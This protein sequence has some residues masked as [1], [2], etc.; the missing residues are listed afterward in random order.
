[1]SDLRSRVI[2]ASSELVRTGQQA[3]ADWQEGMSGFLREA[4]VS[5]YE[6]SQWKREWVRDGGHQVWVPQGSRFQ[7]VYDHAASLTRRAEEAL[8]AVMDRYGIALRVIVNTAA[9]EPVQ[10]YEKL[11]G[12]SRYGSVLPP[13]TAIALDDSGV[14]GYAIDLHSRK[15]YAYLLGQ[16]REHDFKIADVL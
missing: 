13:Q 10:L 15:V 9:F 12:C 4:K 1:M 5:S 11:L 7:R 6:I 3:L 16:S 14:R 2:E 8:S